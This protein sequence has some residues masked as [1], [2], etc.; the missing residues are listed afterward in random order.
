M[1]LATNSLTNS[2]KELAT[3]FNRRIEQLQSTLKSFRKAYPHIF[4]DNFSNPE[5]IMAWAKFWHRVTQDLTPE[6]IQLAIKKSI[7]L[8]EYPPSPALF[9]KYA[10]NVIDP[11]QAYELA[12]E[13]HFNGVAVNNEIV[14][15]AAK[16]LTSNQ[17]S[18]LTTVELKKKFVAVYKNIVEQ[19]LIGNKHE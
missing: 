17:W 7:F 8:S 1:Q 9:R 2:Q 11:E 14:E 12:I 10:L 13:Y 6:Q 16:H 5:V 15:L 18:E 4:G 3:D 19:K